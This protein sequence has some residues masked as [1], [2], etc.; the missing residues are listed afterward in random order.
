MD[1]ND[2]TTDQAEKM[3]KAI[4][5]LVNYL[6]RMVKRMERAGFPPNDSL[7]NSARRAYDDVRSLTVELHYLSCK[8]GLPTGE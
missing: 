3:H 1:S 2:L 5:P 7:F 6:G 4:F 8:S